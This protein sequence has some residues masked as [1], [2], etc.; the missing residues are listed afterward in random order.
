M[1]DEVE[2]AKVAAPTG[3]TIFGKILRGEI[4]C[5]FIYEDEH[6]RFGFSHFLT[7][8]PLTS[9]KLKSILVTGKK[10]VLSYLRSE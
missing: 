1:S 7:I 6:V 5:N 3:D 2:K 10:L 9:I 8:F 4:P